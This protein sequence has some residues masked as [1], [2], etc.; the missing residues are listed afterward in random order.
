MQS[1]KPE[2]GMEWCPGLHHEDLA[3]LAAAALDQLGP[4]Q[5]VHQAAQ[6]IQCGRRLCLLSESLLCVTAPQW[7]R[8][9]P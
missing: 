2:D 9:A 7:Q 3:I 5:A 6:K 1:K 4:R 8:S